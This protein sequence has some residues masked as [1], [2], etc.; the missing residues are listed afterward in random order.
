MIREAIFLGRSNTI[1]WQLQAEK[2]AVDL[3]S[4][5]RMVV[6]IDGVDL[7]SATLGGNAV[8]N[9]FHW[10]PGVPAEG[11][12]N[13]FLKLGPAAEAAGITAGRHFLQLTVYDPDNPDGLVWVSGEEVL[14]S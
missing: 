9:A 6:T 5:T 3:D 1:D 8:G 12:A 14:I 10:T 4:A 11:V 7:D 2:V 13:L